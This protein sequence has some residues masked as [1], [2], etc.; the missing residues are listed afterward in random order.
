MKKISGK[1]KIGL[2]ACSGMGI[3][4]MN[5]MMGSYLCSA[6]L[7]GGFRTESDLMNQTFL[8]KDLV[9]AGLWATF[10]L[11]AKIVDGEMDEFPE[12]AFYNVGTIDDVPVK[13]K[14]L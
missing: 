8:Q 4:L 6:L 7:V 14:T 2:Y 1:F 13:A 9:I 12:A 11:I 5:V 10:I 3:N